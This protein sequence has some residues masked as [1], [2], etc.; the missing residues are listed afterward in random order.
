MAA[1]GE[2]NTSSMRKF[3]H[4]VVFKSFFTTFL[5][6]QNQMVAPQ[7]DVQNKERVCPGDKKLKGSN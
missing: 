1:A 5:G 4:H 2:K 3:H 6:W 7:T